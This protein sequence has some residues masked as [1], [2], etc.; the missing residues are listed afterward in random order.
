MV[1]VG[2][3]ICRLPD[4]FEGDIEL[5]AVTMYRSSEGQFTLAK[6]MDVVSAAKGTVCVI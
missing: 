3:S 4:S 1:A 5:T 2:H 6:V